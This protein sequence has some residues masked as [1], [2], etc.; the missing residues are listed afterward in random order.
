MIQAS[1]SCIS[2]VNAFFLQSD[3]AVKMTLAVPALIWALGAGSL[4]YAYLFPDRKKWLHIVALIATGLFA[5]GVVF[6]ALTPFFMA[7]PA[8]LDSMRITMFTAG[9]IR[10]LASLALLA[11]LVVVIKRSATPTEPDHTL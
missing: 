10:L 7:P 11:C 3:M 1:E 2:T 6:K 4:G 9:A 8:G 5:C